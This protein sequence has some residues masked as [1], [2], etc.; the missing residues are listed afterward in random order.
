MRR[1]ALYALAGIALATVSCSEG[2]AQALT[3]PVI[4]T[5]AGAETE[6]INERFLIALT[7][8]VPCADGGAGELV[9][10]EG[11][12]HSLFHV[13]I[14]GNSFKMKI[15]NQPQGIR[16]TGL[17]T[18]DKYQATGVTQETIGGSFVNGRFSDTFVNNFR[19]VGQGPGNNW[20]VHETFH[21]T[22]NANGELTAFVDH[23]SVECK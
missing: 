13:T 9:Q 15:H 1:L 8:F 20:L 21:V 14:N 19:I 6:T 5:P 11:T 7:V 23:F 16:G 12:L 22:L 2:P 3:A 17:T 4:L 18:G 10:L